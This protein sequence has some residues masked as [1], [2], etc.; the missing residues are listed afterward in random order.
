MMCIITTVL[1][2]YYDQSK[3]IDF[4]AK[5]NQ[6]I[7]TSILMNN[8]FDAIHMR[9]VPRLLQFQNDKKHWPGKISQLQC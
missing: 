9:T 5:T 2:I 6:Q 7:K 3:L 8:L 4:E 1:T